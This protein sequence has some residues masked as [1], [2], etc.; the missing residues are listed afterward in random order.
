MADDAWLV[1]NPGV[2]QFNDLMVSAVQTC[3]NILDEVERNLATMPAAAQTTALA[4]W[5]DLKIQWNNAYNDMVARLQAASAAGQNA[6]EAYRWGD[7]TSY[8]I[9][10]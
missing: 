7:R 10:S 9:M 6:H 8:Q 5:A 4:P 2:Q 1:N 3:R